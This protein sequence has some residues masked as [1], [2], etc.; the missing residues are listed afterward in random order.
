[1]ANDNF[2]GVRK[3]ERRK[4]KGNDSGFTS[5]QCFYENKLPVLMQVTHGRKKS[6]QGPIFVPF[7]QADFYIFSS[8]T[9]L[10]VKG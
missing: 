5:C 9:I 10:Y 6:T 4:T 3:I 7:S 8:Y 2:L 1:M